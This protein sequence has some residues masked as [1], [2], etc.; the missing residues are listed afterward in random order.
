MFHDSSGRGEYS[1]STHR[2][3]FIAESLNIVL[4]AD[5]TS[6]RNVL[7][8]LN[9]MSNCHLGHLPSE[10]DIPRIPNLTVSSKI[11]VD[12]L[13]IDESSVHVGVDEPHS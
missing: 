1:P 9:L 8:T 12:L 7:P 3:R 11:G 10:S 5:V 4:S 6:A 2:T 13:E